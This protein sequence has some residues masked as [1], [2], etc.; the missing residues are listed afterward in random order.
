MSHPLKRKSVR[1]LWRDSK[2]TD[3]ALQSRQLL[4]DT[5]DDVYF[6]NLP[7]VVVEF[8]CE[9]SITVGEAHL[10]GMWLPR[11]VRLMWSALDK[12]LCPAL[13]GLLP[14]VDGL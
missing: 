10:D 13:C 14:S 12:R 5:V 6:G 9:P 7:V 4:L 3:V 2:P 8:G 11:F 1:E